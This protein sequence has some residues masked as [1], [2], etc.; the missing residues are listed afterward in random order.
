LLSL[1]DNEEFSRNSVLPEM[2]LI[3]VGIAHRLA[4]PESFK[5]ILEQVP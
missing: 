3:V 2:T 1:G 5:A 4:D